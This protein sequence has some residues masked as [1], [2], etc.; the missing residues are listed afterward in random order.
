MQE[1]EAIARLKQGDIQ[2]LETL[3]RQYQKP[4]FQA[5]VLICH[6][7]T[8]AE[9]IVQSAFVRAY[10]RIDQFDERRAFGPWFIRGVVNDVLKQV[11]RRRQVPLDP[12]AAEDMA[13]VEAVPEALL[14]AAETKQAIWAA[15]DRL[16][17]RQ[18]AAI[19]LRYYCDLN[20]TRMAELLDCPPNT[21][22]RR[23]HDARRRLRHLLPDWVRPTG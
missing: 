10:E 18:R 23:L 4:A 8:L 19:V 21:V 14:A 16:T 20:D 11:S 7:T 9:D 15:L 3:V 5:A 6:D 12:E 1:R 13:S 17:A 22:R 2:G